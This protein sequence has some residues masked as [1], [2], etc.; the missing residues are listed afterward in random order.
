MMDIGSIIPDG[1]KP[2]KKMNRGIRWRITAGDILA[3][4]GR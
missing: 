3:G 1:Y 4:V 2:V